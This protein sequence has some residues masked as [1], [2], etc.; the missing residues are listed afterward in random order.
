MQITTRW[1][2]M[3]VM[4]DPPDYEPEASSSIDAM[5]K[6]NAANATRPLSK[7]FDVTE[8]CIFA[9]L[10]VPDLPMELVRE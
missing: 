6:L 3:F 8:L 1:D 4:G 7:R 9:F 10:C 2:R 5:A